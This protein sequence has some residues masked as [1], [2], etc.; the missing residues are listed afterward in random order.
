[1]S[2]SSYFSKCKVDHYLIPLNYVNLILILYLF[3]SDQQKN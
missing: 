1:M 3:F 2:N